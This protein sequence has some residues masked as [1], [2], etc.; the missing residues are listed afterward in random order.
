MQGIDITNHASLNE[1][2]AG[3]CRFL[4]REAIRI[5]EGLDEGTAGGSLLSLRPH[6]MRVFQSPNHA[7]RLQQD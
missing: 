6:Q 7:L 5:L 1:E 3:Y 4:N 2:R